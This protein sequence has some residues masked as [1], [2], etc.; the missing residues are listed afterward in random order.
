MAFTVEVDARKL[1]RLLRAAPQELD[2]VLPIVGGRIGQRYLGFHR[3]RRLRGPPGVRG[4]RGTATNPG[5]LSAFRVDT[6]WER[7]AG[8]FEITV[9]TNNLIA[10]QHEYG[11]TLRAF[12]GGKMAVPMPWLSRS[13]VKRARRLLIQSKNVRRAA[14][15]GFDLRR[16]KQGRQKQRGLVYIASKGREML[17]ERR[18]GQLNFLFTLRDQVTIPARLAFRAT[19]REFRPQAIKMF[20][21][22]IGYALAAA[23][24]RARAAA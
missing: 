4:T 8:K 18:G 22:G 7:S 16:G 14:S 5:L 13:Q 12:G 2:N 17:A 11:A 23:R 15:E 19:V 9:G 10:K 21:Q 6:H 3:A 24:R 20:H 1:Q